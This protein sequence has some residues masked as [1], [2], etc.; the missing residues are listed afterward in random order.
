MQPRR[1]NPQAPGW[2]SRLRGPDGRGL[3]RWCLAQVPAGRRTFCGQPCVDQFCVAA[4]NYR[5]AVRERDHGVCAICG[6]D[7][8]ALS[9]VLAAFRDLPQHALPVLEPGWI[10]ASAQH[11]RALLAALGWPPLTSLMR[12][13]WDAD[14]TI[15]LA[16]GGE[17]RLD[18]LRTLC[19]PCN[20]GRSNLEEVQSEG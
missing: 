11:Q 14:H 20:L 16:E 8:Q 5:P 7:T 10:S 2:S 19:V 3:C 18:N 4:G 13:L 12:S 17:N 6:V 9:R 15:P 1:R